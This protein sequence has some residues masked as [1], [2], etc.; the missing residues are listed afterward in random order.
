MKKIII[1]SLFFL[2]VLNF[3]IRAQEVTSQEKFGNTINIGIGIG[4]YS[5]YYMSVRHL[6]PVYHIDFEYTITKN[7]TLAPFVS[8]YTYTKGY[9][10]YASCNLDIPKQY[11]TCRETAMPV[12]AKGTFYFDKLLNSGSKWDFYLAGSIGITITNSK[13]SSGYDGDVN[14]FARN[15]PLFLDAHV[16]TEYHISKTFGITLDISTGAVTLGLAI[17]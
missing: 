15:K 7:L 5:G 10:R 17:H 13:W 2:T 6:M 9:Y 8:L 14:Y 3:N 11:Y 1:V 16:G 4:G 12:G